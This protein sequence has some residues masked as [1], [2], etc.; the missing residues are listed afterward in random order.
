MT[1]FSAK[2]N[3]V[4]KEEKRFSPVREEILFSF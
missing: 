3:Q 2:V 1:L 4:T